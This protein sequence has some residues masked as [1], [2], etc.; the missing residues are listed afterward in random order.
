MITTIF[1]INEIIY[2]LIFKLKKVIE[3]NN[4]VIS[5]SCKILFNIKFG[6]LLSKFIILIVL[7]F[8]MSLNKE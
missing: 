7:L 1:N 3:E 4:N 2:K 6:V 8:I 5:D